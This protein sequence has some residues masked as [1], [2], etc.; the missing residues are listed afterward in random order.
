MYQRNRNNNSGFRKSI[1]FRRSFNRRGQGRNYRKKKFFDPSLLVR[2]ATAEQPGEYIPKHVFSDFQLS[3]KLKEN[4][5]SKGF[6]NPTPIQDQVIPLLLD[7]RD[8]I[9][10]ARTGTGKTVAFLIPLINK[11]YRDRN[12]KALIVAPTRELALQIEME[13][14]TLV[15]QMQLYSVACIGG[16]STHGQIAKLRTRPNF[17]IGT[18]GR[19]K[20]LSQ[21][22]ILRFTD[23]SSIVLDE[24]DR[25]LDMGFL[26]D[27]KQIIAALPRPR[28]SLFF[29][30]TL[31]DKMR[32]LTRDFLN[33]PVMISAQSNNASINVDQDV[34][35][36]NGK[37]KEDLLHDL[38][39]RKEF[40]KVLI[41]GRTKWGIEK[42]VKNLKRRGFNAA[43]IHG[44]KS[45]NQRQ[46][47]LADFKTNRV[48]I[49][50]ATDIASRG[51]HIDNVTH[52]INYDLPES[53][54]DYIHRIGRTGRLDQK[55]TALSFID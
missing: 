36:I 42:L 16:V 37:P 40:H 13:F 3:R 28:Q 49:L 27:V 53:Y 33:N 45:Q 22:R 31:P 7:N 9:G 17:V 46:R 25:M 20:D 35:K 44:N 2:K 52:V 38:L 5:Q 12:Q 47:A 11:I 10:M 29:S 32:N 21:R 34:I 14:K 6:K 54:E 30:A 50:L 1:R 26:P 39:I 19:L 4:I 15:S 24:V 18:P 48:Q 41:F 55:G 43:S 8:V 51:L 23:Y